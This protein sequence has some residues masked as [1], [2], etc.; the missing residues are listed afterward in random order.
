MLL[1]HGFSAT[2]AAWNPQVEALS[3][4]YQLITWDLRGHS[5]SDSPADPAAYSEALSIDD[6]RAL[7]DTQGVR[8][9]N[10]ENY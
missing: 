9:K 7:L 1:T 10:S 2:T 3:E 6:M 5:Q 8:A 4:H